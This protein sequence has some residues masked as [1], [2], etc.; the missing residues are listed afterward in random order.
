MRASYV[1]S[2]IIPG[3]VI[4]LNIYFPVIVGPA[5]GLVL[6][7]FCWHGSEIAKGRDAVDREKDEQMRELRLWDVAHKADWR[8]ARIIL[9]IKLD[10]NPAAVIAMISQLKG[11]M[12]SL[13]N[14]LENARRALRR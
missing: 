12:V 7:F 3:C 5:V 11:E 6:C 9:G 14:Q 10:S 13:G 4:Y 8:K 2:A 1:L